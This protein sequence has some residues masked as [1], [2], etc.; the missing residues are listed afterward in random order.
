MMGTKDSIAYT[1][2]DGEGKD[3]RGEA[4]IQER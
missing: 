2:V 4:T 1:L 3:N